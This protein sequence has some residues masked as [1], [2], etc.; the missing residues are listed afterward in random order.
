MQREKD[1]IPQ[2]KLFILGLFSTIGYVQ[3]LPYAIAN[4]IL[5]LVPIFFFF[6]LFRRKLSLGINEI[7]FSLLWLLSGIL[8]YIITTEIDKVIISPMAIILRLIGPILIYF[9]GKNISLSYNEC[10]KVFTIIF[11][12][13]TTVVLIQYFILG[14]VRLVHYPNNVVEWEQ[15]ASGNLILRRVTGLLGNSNTLAAFTLIVYLFIENYLSE[16]K[17]TKRFILVATLLIISIFAKSRNVMIVS[18][19][20]AFI[21]IISSSNISLKFTTTLVILAI[22][23]LLYTFINSDFIEGIFRFQSFQDADNSY[24]IRTLVTLEAINIWRNNFIYFGGGASSEA[25]YL[26]KYSFRNYSEMLYTKILLEQ[27]IMGIIV[28]L[29]FVIKTYINSSYDKFR[30]SIMKYII[31]SLLLISFM[32]AVFYHQQLFFISFLI[33]G[34]ISNPKFVK[35]DE[36]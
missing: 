23:I 34:I 12:I 8:P 22:S 4:V 30:K 19:L 10:A 20:I 31:L 11:L 14:E 29:G 7:L 3:Y 36:T 15:I 35:N 27:G 2:L 13:N 9:I 28:Y 5:I 25:F 26:A 21:K 17:R 33:F 24:T 18:F 32:E 6:D 1:K 16:R